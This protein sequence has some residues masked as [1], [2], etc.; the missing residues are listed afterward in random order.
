MMDV[1]NV[2]E[3]KSK[4]AYED[5]LLFL[6]GLEA[7]ATATRYGKAIERFVEKQF[8][9]SIQFV[10]A[11]H[12]NSLTYTD[13]YKYRNY[14]RKQ[15]F[16]ASTINNEMTALF[17]L[18]KELNKIQREN[19]VH[20][21]QLN[22]DQL[23]TKSLKIVETNSSGDLT[24]EEV[25]EWIDYIK[26][27]EM[28]NKESKWIFLHIARLTGLRKESLAQLTYRDLRKSGSVWQI[29]STLKGKTTTISIN[30]E[31][32]ELLF[33]LWKDKGNKDEKILKMSTKTMER[34]LNDI[35]RIFEIPEER[36]ITIHSL[37]GLSI[38]EAYLAS[39]KDILV[40]QKH[41]NHSSIETT[42]NY[43]KNREGAISQPT[44]YMGRSFDENCVKEIDK[45]QW[46]EIFTQLSR[47]AQYEILNIIEES[48]YPQ[49]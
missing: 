37:R 31:D 13:M 24:W 25:D 45:K 46:M 18:F 34:L 1:T 40:A 39:G 35:K 2:V 6:D 38:Y 5:I 7:E 28:A 19:G 49:Q 22:V 30:D 16:A 9:V 48:G 3:L 21:Y 29:V 20:P 43:I 23:R 42:Y 12:F 15:G 32:A 14:L 11:R 27:S 17:N 41:A 33:G 10:Q 44:L 4:T 8:K 26:H 36:N 47:S